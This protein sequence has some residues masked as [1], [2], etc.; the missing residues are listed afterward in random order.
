MAV[1]DN[2]DFEQWITDRIDFSTHH[3]KTG[4]TGDMEEWITDRIDLQ[5]YQE[6]AAAPTVDLI[7]TTFA[8]YSQ[9]VG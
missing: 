7:L 9:P 4:N 3:P 6:V 5:T 2:G 8:G 1:V